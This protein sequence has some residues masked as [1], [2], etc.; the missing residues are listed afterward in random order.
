MRS[1][2]TMPDE[3]IIRQAQRGDE[4]SIRDFG[5]TLWYR[6]APAGAQRALPQQQRDYLDSTFIKYWAEEYIRFVIEDDGSALV[7]AEMRAKIVGLAMAIP[8]DSDAAVATLSRLNV[9]PTLGVKTLAQ[10][11]L[12]Q[13]ES[14]VP[15]AVTMLETCVPQADPQQVRFFEQQGYHRQELMTIG[16]GPPPHAFVK[17]TKWLR[18]DLSKYRRN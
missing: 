9:L 15:R 13:C 5:F 17:M 12:E 4:T 11:L 16:N 10:N 7:V 6:S 2:I 3:M 14:C 18:S 1:Q 8:K